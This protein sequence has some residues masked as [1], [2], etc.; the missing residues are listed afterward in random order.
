MRGRARRTVAAPFLEDARARCSARNAA[1]LERP[2]TRDSA[3]RSSRTSTGISRPSAARS[4]LAPHV[5]AAIDSAV[6]RLR[7][8]RPSDLRAALAT[9]GVAA[10]AGGLRRRLAAPRHGGRAG[11]RH[12]PR[13][14]AFRGVG[15]RRLLPRRPRHRPPDGAVRRCSR[16][17]RSPPERLIAAGEGSRLEDARAS[18]SRSSRSRGVPLIEHVLAQLR[19]RR[20]RVA[21]RS[22]STRTKRTAR[23]TSRERFP[24][25]VSTVLRPDDALSLES[26]RDDPRACRRRGGLLVSTVD[27]FCPPQDFAAFARAAA[28]APEDDDRAR[29]D[30]LRRTTRSRSG[31]TSDAAG[32]IRR[33]GGASGD[34]VTAG[35]Y[36]LSGRRARRRRRR[37]RSGACATS[38]RGSASRASRCAPSRSGRSWTWT[39]PRTSRLAESLLRAADGR[40]GRRR[41]SRPRCWGVYRE[42]AHSPGRETDDARDPAGHGGRARG[43]R[44]PGRAQVRR[45]AAGDDRRRG[46]AARFSS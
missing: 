23:P 41:V 40:C 1:V 26:F 31:W 39:A 22:S 32:R 15:G 20:N 33:V 3:W 17:R 25:L 11:P 16:E 36:V 35:I 4:G 37:L 12:A 6:V 43:A 21:P 45:R 30:P 34:A 13:L 28:A 18:R 19:G 2:R 42:L 5:D 46:R 24:A 7:E 14:G 27:A 9:L 38:S 10:A 8:A 29:R 44:L